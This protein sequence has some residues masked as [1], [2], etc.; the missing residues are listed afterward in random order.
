MPSRSGPQIPH[1]PMPAH[2][3]QLRGPWEYRWLDTPPTEGLPFPPAGRVKMPA[4]WQSLFGRRSGHARFTRR[5]NRPTNVGPHQ[6]VLIVLERPAGTAA[7][8]VND[9]HLGTTTPAAESARFDVTAV[10]RRSN[11]L[12]V[13]VEFDPATPAD[14]DELW[15]T[16]AIEI[17]E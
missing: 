13:D 3:I 9:H 15:R 4:G 6:R 8:R 12:V 10:L 2:R 11:E 5:F 16:V 17:E 7:L 14:L 1:F